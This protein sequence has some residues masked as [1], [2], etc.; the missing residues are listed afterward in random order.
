M[1]VST[2][3]FWRGRFATTVRELG[4]YA[5]IALVVPGGTLILASLWIF[6]RRA[7]L[8]G[9]A[10]QAWR[11]LTVVLTVG[12]SVMFPSGMSERLVQ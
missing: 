5:L 12:A 3:N 6:R 11:F 10:R 9:H 2:V 7:W 1:L 8:A 4:P